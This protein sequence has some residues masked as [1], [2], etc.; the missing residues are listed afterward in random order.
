MSELEKKLRQFII[1]KCIPNGDEIVLYGCT[2]ETA[3]LIEILI[4]IG[5]KPLAVI[6]GDCRKE[7]GYWYGIPVMMPRH[8]AGILGHA[9]IIIWSSYSSEMYSNMINLGV[10]NSRI[11]LID[12]LKESDEYIDYRIQSL[13][14]SLHVYSELKNKNSEHIL[15]VAPRASGDIYL[16]LSLLSEW[17]R[18]NTIDRKICVVGLGNNAADLAQMFGVERFEY[19]SDSDRR[20]LLFAYTILGDLLD[21]KIL[22]PWEINV[23]NSYFPKT[24]SELVFYDK[25][26]YEVF[27][28]AIGTQGVFPS[29]IVTPN[30][31][32]SIILSPYAYSSPAPSLSTEFWENVAEKMIRKGYLVY[33]VGYGDKE[34]TVKNTVKIQFSYSEAL[35]VLGKCI[36][37]IASRSGLCDIVHNADCKQVILFSNR[38]LETSTSFYGMKNNFKDFNGIEINCDQYSEDELIETIIEKVCE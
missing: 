15:M 17:K 23:R 4:N 18:Q 30:K 12:I 9:Y 25:Y 14:K 1:D 3:I 29:K 11:L 19:I 32:K 38:L 2:N 8:N 7:G 33:T 36:G 24:K 13:K 27:N 16:S 22:S 28:L 6:D 34:P 10:D 21:I 26:K 37:F 20:Q 35:E 5:R 31:E